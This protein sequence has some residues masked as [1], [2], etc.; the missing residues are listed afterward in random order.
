MIEL[1]ARSE[2]A[3]MRDAG[4]IVAQI[5]A[6]VAEAAQAGVRLAEL[7]ALAAEIITSRGARSSFQG[8]H[9][10]WAPYPYPGVVCLSV[11]EAIV[12]G[13]PD[14]RRLKTGDLLSIDCGVAVDG[15]H[16]D[17]AVTVGIGEIDPRSQRL[18]DTA[19]AA[20]TAGLAAAQPGAHLGDVSYAIEQLI[21]GAG[22]GIPRGYGG[23]GIGRAM[24]EEPH[25]S[26][27]GQPARGLTLRQGLVL[28]IEPMVIAG[29]GDDCH[30]TQDGW[31]VVTG[32]GSRA[33]H[34]E[35]TVAITADGPVV[36]TEP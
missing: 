7:D 24:H 33:A 21:R 3:H 10:S 1:K 12:H 18:A 16:A 19:R 25:V 26:N 11:N 9:P 8:Y 15:Y 13:I 32:D 35:H 2:V 36:L 28:A 34:A 27:T 20:L 22:Y 29:G 6:D 31:T 30:P 5:L 14:Q 23:H 4:R 17:A